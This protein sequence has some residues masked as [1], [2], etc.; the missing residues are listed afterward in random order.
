MTITTPVPHQ[1]YTLTSRPSW[2]L[3]GGFLSLL[4][5]LLN[6]IPIYNILVVHLAH[7]NVLKDWRKNRS[8]FQPSRKFR[9][10]TKKLSQGFQ[11]DASISYCQSRTTLMTCRILDQLP[12]STLPAKYK[13]VKK[14][15]QVALCKLPMTK[16]AS[17]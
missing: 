5:L 10:S 2:S 13:L 4:S 12:R 9:T 15:P 6:S 14:N 1:Y 16:S 8:K 7:L 17:Y 11:I 3:L